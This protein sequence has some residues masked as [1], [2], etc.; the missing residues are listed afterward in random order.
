[1]K[2]GA[3]TKTNLLQYQEALAFG[4][5]P[6]YT[7][8][9]QV[10]LSGGERV[11]VALSAFELALYFEN[12]VALHY[13][14]EGRL[15]KVARPD[16]HR[17]RGLSHQVLVTHRRS[18]Q[19]GGGIERCVLLTEDADALVTGAHE[20][21]VQVMNELRG[22]SIALEYAKPGPGQALAEILPAL[23]RA[24]MF[25]QPAARRDAER[26]HSIYVASPCFRPTNTTRSCSRRRKGARI[27]AACSASCI[28]TRST[29][30]RPP[31]SL[32]NT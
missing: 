23:Q 6:R 25:D 18:V 1:M 26:F 4:Q 24:A 30:A 7:A 9:L 21:A 13:D 17:R 11:Y 27:R 19:Q 14:L 29:D 15:T 10:L 3:E 5:V 2:V 22:N 31:P 16:H 8:G 20:K 12:D 32:P 28:A